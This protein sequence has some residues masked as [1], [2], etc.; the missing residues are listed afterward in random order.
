MFERLQDFATALQEQFLVRAVQVS[1]YFCFAFGSRRI[2]RQG[3]YLKGEP[4]A[5]RA[6]CVREKSSQR[7]GRGSA[8]EFA[9]AD[10]RILHASSG[11]DLVCRL[12]LEKKK[13]VRLG[14]FADW[15]NRLRAIQSP[16]L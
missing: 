16:L 14:Q 9:I 8:V 3:G 10:R 15:C 2:L 6:D 5:G 13:F 11:R 7:I 1:Q 12:L 4:E